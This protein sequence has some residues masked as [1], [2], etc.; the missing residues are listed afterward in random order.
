MSAECWATSSTISCTRRLY[1]YTC[2]T[3]LC[4][5]PPIP[6]AHCF[7]LVRWWLIRPVPLLPASCDLLLSTGEG[8]VDELCRSSAASCTASLLHLHKIDLGFL[9]QHTGQDR[10]SFHLQFDWIGLSWLSGG[11]IDRFFLFPCGRRR[12]SLSR[13]DTAGNKTQEGA[14]WFVFEVSAL[15][16]RL[17]WE[18]GDC[19]MCL[20]VLHP[21]GEREEEILCAHPPFCAFAQ[22][23]HSDD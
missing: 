4:F 17:L 19:P 21:E 9:V 2:T 23:N 6:T 5:F 12:R 10:L 16:D 3:L 22:T 20:W 13:R 8:I 18:K 7:I 14:E 11:R 1:R 15:S